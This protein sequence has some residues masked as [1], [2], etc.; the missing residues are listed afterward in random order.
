MNSN[1]QF[2]ATFDVS[3]K[4]R[5]F[6]NKLKILSKYFQYRFF[7]GVL[8]VLVIS[9]SLSLN[10]RS[11]RRNINTYTDAEKLELIGLIDG[12]LTIY[13]STMHGDDFARFHTTNDYL[14]WHRDHFQDLEKYILEQDPNGALGYNKY[15]PFPKWDP[16]TPVP[17]YF[18]GW[19]P[20]SN[21]YNNISSKCNDPAATGCRTREDYLNTNPG[22]KFN[23]NNN[24]KFGTTN[25]APLPAFFKSTGSLCSPATVYTSGA[26]AYEFTD[27]SD[28][29]DFSQ[30]FYHNRGHISF[31]I[32]SF[33]SI[34]EQSQM[35]NLSSNRASAVY[36][37]WL[38][39]AWV[40][41]MWWDW[42]A[43]CRH[44]NN[45]TTIKD[46]YDEPNGFTV[47]TGTTRTLNI[48]GNI[49]KVQGKIIVEPDATLIIEN[50]QIL[51]ILD[52][53][54]TNQSCDI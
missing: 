51:E 22:Y 41:D 30:I 10:A 32:N 4:L 31:D 33:G 14:R 40:D 43:N 5:R 29:S 6:S 35:G 50:G 17:V 39:H 48:N 21:P 13:L 11:V 44:Q 2:I 52:D 15:V 49:F 34:A 45:G 37:F 47:A 24:F 19:D 9:L 54:F 42:D 8:F 12:W 27:F 1:V 28:Y 7:K 36:V 25:L 46:A 23:Q 20:S 53:Y 26:R 38:W 3:S 18:N 16:N